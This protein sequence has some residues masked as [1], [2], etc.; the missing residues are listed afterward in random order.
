MDPLGEWKGYLVVVDK[1][2]QEFGSRTVPGY[3]SQMG[4]VFLQY[5]APSLVEERSFDGRN[6]P[7]QVWQYDQLKS[8]STRQQNQVFIFVDQELIGRQYT[9]IHS[10][11]LGEVK[12]HKWQYH[13]TRHTNAGPILMRPLPSTVGITLES[14]FLIPSLLVTKERGS[15]D[16]K[17]DERKDCGCHP[18]LERE[19]LLENTYQVL[20]KTASHIR[21]MS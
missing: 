15:I 12:D 2:D 21:Y 14:E 20:L 19:S 17:L 1:V 6:Y 18:E 9:L 16:F 10:S 7:Y 4:R 5:G 13:L 8:S 11:A 3:R